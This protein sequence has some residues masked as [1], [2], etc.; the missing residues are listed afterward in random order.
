MADEIFVPE[1]LAT[2]IAGLSGFLMFCNMADNSSVA[3]SPK[4]QIARRVASTI[5]SYRCLLARTNS[6]RK[7]L[8]GASPRQFIEHCSGKNASSV[9]SYQ[10]IEEDRAAAIYL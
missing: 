7:H 4:D 5:N 3:R 8:R 10:G 2:R 6:R 9:V 1:T